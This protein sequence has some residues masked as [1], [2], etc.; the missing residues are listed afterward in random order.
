MLH[1]DFFQMHSK[2]IIRHFIFWLLFF[3]VSLFNELYFSSSFTQHPD[4]V[5]FYKSVL[6]QL[7]V[8]SIKIVVVYY[9]IY[10]I[11]PRWSAHQSNIAA[12]SAAPFN[13][14]RRTSLK[15]L[16]EFIFVILVGAFCIRL[17]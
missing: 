13:A 11:I 2:R 12:P 15:Y 14:P 17:M 1:V 9:S 4:W 8:Y 16:L 3:C 5:I 10:N 7:L 6:S